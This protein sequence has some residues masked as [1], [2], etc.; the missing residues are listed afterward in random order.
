M[1]LMRHHTSVVRLLG[2]SLHIAADK[3]MAEKADHVMTVS[4]AAKRYMTDVDKIRR[5]D[6]D[7]VYLG[8]D[9]DKYAPDAEQRDAVRREFSFTGNDFVIGYVAAFTPGKGHLQLIQA[10]TEIAEKV[11]SAKLLLKGKAGAGRGR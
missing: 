4:E 5:D 11:P 7:V 3:W 10:F 9:F 6:I 1:A 8:F 2:S